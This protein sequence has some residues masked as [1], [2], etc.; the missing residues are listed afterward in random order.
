M[1][2]TKLNKLLNS[3]IEMEIVDWSSYDE[4]ITNFNDD[5]DE[6]DDNELEY[7]K[8]TY[9]R[10]FLINA[11]GI[12]KEGYSMC[13]HITDFTPYFFIKIPKEW[14]EK[15]VKYMMME[16]NKNGDIKYYI[17]QSL[18]SSEIVNKK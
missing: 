17:K 16:I 5:D 6:D 7:K 9:D 18:I 2:R 15:D 12:S 13:V 1:F 3:D 11:Y 4:V 14:E 10:K 8:K